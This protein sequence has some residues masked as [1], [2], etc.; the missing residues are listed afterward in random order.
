MATY[1]G[2][3]LVQPTKELAEHVRKYIPLTDIIPFAPMLAMKRL[4]SILP[5]PDQMQRPIK[6]GSLWWPQGASRWATG[7]YIATESQLNL[8]RP[9]VYSAASYNAKALV[10]SDDTTTLT[11]NMWMLPPR[12]LFQ[13]PPDSG[14][15][16]KWVVPKTLTDG[17]AL[18]LLPLVDDRYFWW[19]RV[20]TISIMDSSMTWATLFSTIATNLGIT[21]TTDAIN[22]AYLTVPAKFADYQ[23]YLPLILDLACFTIGQRFLRHLDGTTLTQN[24]GTALTAVQTGLTNNQNRLAG[25]QFALDVA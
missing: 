2:I 14:S 20:S 9:L 7:F 15:F 18:Y 23:M 3:G 17:D 24:A 12:P 6:L 10:L 19:Q 5:Y 13:N 16:L 21:I 11:A 4:I 1:G 8:I 22:S 25:G